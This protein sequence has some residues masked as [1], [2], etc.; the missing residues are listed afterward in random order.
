MIDK[1]NIERDKL[2]RYAIYNFR[3]ERIQKE[4]EQKNMITSSMQYIYNKIH[5]NVAKLFNIYYIYG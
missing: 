4:I 5:N 2:R 3:L 1:F